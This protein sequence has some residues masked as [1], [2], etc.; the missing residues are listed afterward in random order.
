MTKPCLHENKFNIGRC[1]WAVARQT[2][3]TKKNQY[4]NSKDFKMD[5]IHKKLNRK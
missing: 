5:I 4:L 2:E 1:A 3:V